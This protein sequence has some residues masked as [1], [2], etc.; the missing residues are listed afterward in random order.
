MVSDMYTPHI[1]GVTNHIQLCKKYLEELGHTVHVFTWGDPGQHDED[2]GVVRS[3][4]LPFFGTG[5][6]VPMGI[7]AR[8][9]RL[10]STMDVLHAHHP[11]VSAEV[12]LGHAHR[13]VTVFT[14]HTRYDLY[15][16]IYAGFVPVSVSHALI[17]RR[18][19]NIC[20]RCDRI[21]AP[22]PR[23]ATWLNEWGACPGAVVLNNAVEIEAYAR[24]LSPLSKADLGFAE[25]DVLAV[26][27]GR[28]AE[29]KRISILVDA[30]IRAASA[31][32]RLKLVM[33]GDG[34]SMPAMRKRLSEAGMLSRVHLA[35]SVSYDRCPGYLAAAD[36]FATASD[37]ETFPLVAIEAA[38]AGLPAVG[39]N[40]PG[41]ADV[42]VDGETGLLTAL[43]AG[44]LSDALLKLA[45]DTGLRSR[46]STR[47][48]AEARRYDARN[49][50]EKLAR[51]YEEAIAEKRSR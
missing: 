13:A 11:F 6:R 43:D 21:I 25:D 22:S 24:P 48:E 36:L 44:Q 27:V 20:R 3:P 29:E 51:I 7:S 4:A 49:A 5:W 38:A 37:S 12:A 28:I 8:A 2:A 42:V 41:V 31:D 19:T 10:L 45:G 34:P 18:L 33:V 16:E 17:R 30:F 14:S 47:A 50:A 1:S 23:T 9:R 40:A 39:V 46:M 15:S 35:G 26:Y 32:P